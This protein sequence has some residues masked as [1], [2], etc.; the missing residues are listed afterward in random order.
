MAKDL[1]ME[2]TEPIET[3]AYARRRVPVNRRIDLSPCAGI[4]SR[5][6]VPADRAPGGATRLTAVD[7]AIVALHFR[8]VFA[9]LAIVGATGS[10]GFSFR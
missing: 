6:Y 7:L 3:G 10:L 2:S 5:I 4:T 8:G 1:P 9:V